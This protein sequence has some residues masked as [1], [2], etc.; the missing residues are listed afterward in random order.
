MPVL[1]AVTE[2]SL[3]FARRTPNQLVTTSVSSIFPPFR[4]T[5]SLPSSPSLTNSPY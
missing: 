1:I 3:A 4:L 2:H 5:C